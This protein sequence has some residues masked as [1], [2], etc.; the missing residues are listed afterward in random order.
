MIQIW[1][2]KI[3]RI[4]RREGCIWGFSS[5]FDWTLN[6]VVGHGADIVVYDGCDVD[7]CLGV[8]DIVVVGVE[9]IEVVVGVEVIEV[10]V[11]ICLIIK[12]KQS[13]KQ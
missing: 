9:V 12:N 1:S 7:Y 11:A 4:L 3:N 10:V 5:W 13:L 8:G 6:F 2:W